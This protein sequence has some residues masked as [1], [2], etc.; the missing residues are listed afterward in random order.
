MKHFWQNLQSELSGSEWHW[1]NNR[2]QTH[3][4]DTTVYTRNRAMRL[5]LCCKSGGVPF[6]R[7]S[8]DPFD[9]ND[10]FTAEFAEDDP[11]AWKPFAISNPKINS[12]TIAVPDPLSQDADSGR[13]R[14]NSSAADADGRHKRSRPDANLSQVLPPACVEALQTLLDEQGSEGCTVTDQMKPSSQRRNT[15]QKQR[16]SGHK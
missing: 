16:I 2:K 13:K 11:A 8:G 7:I 10:D 14:K 1:D 4:I 3:V 5:P 15:R 6:V 9:E 12:D